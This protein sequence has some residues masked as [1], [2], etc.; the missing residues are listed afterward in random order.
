M[1]GLVFFCHPEFISGS[2]QFEVLRSTCKMLKRVQHD[3][4]VFN[5][6]EGNY[7]G[8]L[9]QENIRNFEQELQYL[10][11]ACFALKVGYADVL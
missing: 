10:Q 8:T 6:R 7:F 4:F 9:R 11:Q 5:C 2:Y 3:G 1:G